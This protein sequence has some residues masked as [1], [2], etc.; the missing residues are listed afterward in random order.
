M[1]PHDVNIRGVHRRD[2]LS[3]QELL[4]VTRSARGHGMAA[5]AI[6]LV[7]AVGTSAGPVSA[8]TVLIA[9]ALLALMPVRGG[10]VGPSL[11]AACTLAALGLGWGWLAANAVSQAEP[12]IAIIW[13][14]AAW[15]TMLPSVASPTF[16]APAWTLLVLGPLVIA[17]FNT[18]EERGAIGAAAVMIAAAAH[19]V[20]Y[21]MAEASRR[22]GGY[23]YDRQELEALVET[24]H[25]RKEENLSQH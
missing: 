1:D 16:G 7:F 3:E 11:Y 18:V 17:S 12:M 6:A 24:L 5:N 2:Y 19:Y 10:V 15:L 8:A 13:A 14:L 22:A 23:D 21:A 25:Q 20:V 9:L 4:A